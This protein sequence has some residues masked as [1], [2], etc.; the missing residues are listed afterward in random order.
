MPDIRSIEPLRRRICSIIDIGTAD[1]FISR[2][3]D[4]SYTLVI[5]VNLAVTIAYTF[6]GAEARCGG[7]PLDIEAAT[8]AFFAADCAL[9]IWT[10][11]FRGPGMKEWR[12]V[13]KYVFS[14]SGIVDLLSFLP[15]YLPVFF[16]SGAVAFRMFRVVRIFRLFR[17]NAYYDSLN[18]ITQVLASKAQ[19]LLSSVFII[20]VLMI[21]SS[22]CMYLLEHD[23]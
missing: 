22:L 23:A 18:V 8:V 2:A 1:D 17:I 10:A 14:F 16:P 21:A 5:L 13:C 20:L 11:K 6:D 3:Y 4:I 15:Y 12:V 19:Q 7:L 9:R